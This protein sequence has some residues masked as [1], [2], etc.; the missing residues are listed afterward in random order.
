M[1]TVVIPT[2]TSGFAH[3]AKLLP[4]L[5]KEK[6]EIVI[7]DN[8][9]MDGTSTLM[10]NYQ[11]TVVFNKIKKNFSQSCNQGARLSRNPYI[12]FLNNDTTV[13]PGFA[14]RMVHLME[15]EKAGMVGCKIWLMDMKRLQHAGVAFN[16]NGFPYELGLPIPDMSPGVSPSDPRATTSREV[17]AV[18][19]VCMM[20]RREDFES[21][22]GFDE[23]YI[24][25]WE[26]N[27]LCL[28]FKESGKKIWYCAES[29]VYHRLHGSKNVGR[30]D[31]EIQNRNRY[32]SRWV[33]NSK[34]FSL[35]SCSTS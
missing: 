19:A 24:N 4:G 22:G 21:V 30:F 11:C 8:N 5:S 14:D 15:R 3:L 25:G 35:V 18:T 20:V 28:K 26:D 31:K 2:T 17:D 27:D 7:V 34:V 9:S 16:K 12:L 32:E 23:E 33:S 10:A 1:I 29:E 13:T 6:L